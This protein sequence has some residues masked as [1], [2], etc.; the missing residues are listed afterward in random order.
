MCKWTLTFNTEYWIINELPNLWREEPDLVT[1][2]W[3]LCEQTH[4]L[5]VLFSSQ[6]KL[7]LRLVIKRLQN[8]MMRKMDSAA[9]HTPD[10]YADQFGA[11]GVINDRNREGGRRVCGREEKEERDTELY[12]TL[13]LIAPLGGSE[14]L[15]MQ[16]WASSEG[17]FGCWGIPQTVR[18]HILRI[19]PTSFF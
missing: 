8:E 6:I 17:A 12:L 11:W 19:P 14:T 4:G 7:L 16:P 1:S 13:L 18:R 2:G 15:T 3:C 9:D 5:L 10:Q